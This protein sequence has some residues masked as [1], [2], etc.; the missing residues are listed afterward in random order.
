MPADGSG[1]P[2]KLAEEGYSVEGWSPDGTLIAV[3]TL[4]PDQSGCMAPPPGVCFADLS[5]VNADGQGEPL[6]LGEGRSASWS[7]DGQR[8]LFYR[9]VRGLITSSS[10][11]TY[12]VVT[13]KEVCL[14]DAITG[15]TMVLVSN[16]LN[17][18]VE[19]GTVFADGGWTDRPSW[20]P[21][22]SR[23]LYGFEASNTD[24]LYVVNADGSGPPTKLADGDIRSAEWSPDGRQIVYSWSLEIYIVAADGS[25]PPRK[26]GAGHSPHWS[27]DG[28]RIVVQVG[29]T[30]DAEIWVI[31]AE[32]GERSSVENL[33]DYHR[34][35]LAAG[36]VWSPDGSLILTEA[37]RKIYALDPEGDRPATKLGQGDSPVWSPDGE[38]VA[39]RRLPPASDN[40][41]RPHGIL[42]AN[43]DGSGVTPLVDDL[44]P[45]CI[46]YAW[47]PDGQ[48]IA[49]S[50]TWCGLL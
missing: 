22:G 50:S 28:S 34:A 36:P 18:R 24:E 42:I 35:A 30:P 4:N 13:A 47:S 45:S 39:F 21:D 41:P 2:V 32:T 19:G 5:V 29:W 40:I 1:P 10:G 9:A 20:S 14:A 48:R 15:E 7:P 11:L 6:G 43:A 27:P 12:P 44:V 31:D 8:L 26:L 37:D 17:A 46:G 33:V 25:Q 38:H 16:G 49:F 23:V 3:S